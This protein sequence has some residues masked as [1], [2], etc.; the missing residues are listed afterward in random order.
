MNIIASSS[1]FLKCI[2][3]VLGFRISDS[4]PATEKQ[5]HLTLQGIWN[6]SVRVFLSAIQLIAITC[7][8]S[9]YI[10]DELIS[11]RLSL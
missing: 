9:F 6:I 7:V 10:N 5:S 1:F 2:I 4:Q 3:L 8:V 11:H